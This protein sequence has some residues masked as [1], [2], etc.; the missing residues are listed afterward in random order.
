MVRMIALPQ[1]AII[2]KTGKGMALDT[3]N[4]GHA[5]PDR[6]YKSKHETLAATGLEKPKRRVW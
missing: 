1:P 2:A 6:W 5:L 4:S 3:L